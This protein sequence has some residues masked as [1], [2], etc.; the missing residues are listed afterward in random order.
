M[1]AVSDMPVGCM[2]HP[3]R[4]TSHTG[5]DSRVQDSK[6]RRQT[7]ESIALMQHTLLLQIFRTESSAA[8]SCP[9]CLSFSHSCCQVE[10][11]WSILCKVVEANCQC[12]WNM[13]LVKAVSGLK[14]Q[15]Q[16]LTPAQL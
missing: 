3:A 6:A 15:V 11:G 9:T 7:G 5:A 8:L 16:S 2:G 4:N 13:P 10:S 1:C 12:V 14:F